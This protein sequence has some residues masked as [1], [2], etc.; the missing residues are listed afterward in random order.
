MVRHAAQ[1]DAEA[2]AGVEAW[3][4]ALLKSPGGA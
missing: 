3:A 4:H 1:T 2:L